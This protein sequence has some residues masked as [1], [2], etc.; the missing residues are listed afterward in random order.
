MSAWQPSE[1]ELHLLRHIIKIKGNLH[2]T[3][4]AMEEYAEAAAAIARY[5][6]GEAPLRELADELADTE[7]MCAQ[8]C[9]IIPELSERISK[10]RAVKLASIAVRF[11]FPATPQ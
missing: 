3:A 2:Q 4:K 10:Q 6:I 9:E 7:I 5:G 8:L 11:G 1:T